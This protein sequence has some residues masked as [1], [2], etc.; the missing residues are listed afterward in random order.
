[1]CRQTSRNLIVLV[2]LTLIARPAPADST[3]REKPSRQPNILW[4]IAENIGPDLACYGTTEVKTPNLDRLSADGLRYTRAFATAPICSTSR[5]AFMTGMYQTA[6]GA[7][8]HRSHC[9]PGIDEHFHLPAG[10]R[11]HHQSSCRRGLLHRQHRHH[12]RSARRHRQD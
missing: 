10:V 2:L 8:N 4:L 5:S 1:M 7:Q 11:T 3:G 12:G 9:I 6:I